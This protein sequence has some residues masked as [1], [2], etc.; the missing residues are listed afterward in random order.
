MVAEVERLAKRFEDW[1]SRLAEDG[2][3][4]IQAR[5]RGD[6][7]ALFRIEPH[8]RAVGFGFLLQRNHTQRRR[9]VDEVF[10]TLALILHRHALRNVEQHRQTAD[11]RLGLGDDGSRFE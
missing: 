11:P 8:D 5:G 9:G 4:E 7:L 3:T 6:R 2:R 10:G 1:A